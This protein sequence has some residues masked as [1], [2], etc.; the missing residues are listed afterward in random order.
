MSNKPG[1]KKSA[2]T[3]EGTNKKDLD[4]KKKVN[5]LKQQST[6]HK[7]TAE[8]AA[9]EREW[10]KKRKDVK[11]QPVEKVDKWEEQRKQHGLAL[12]FMD[13]NDVSNVKTYKKIRDILAMGA[14]QDSWSEEKK[15]AQ[16]ARL[17]SMSE[18]EMDALVAAI[19]DEDMDENVNG[20]YKKR[21][22]SKR[23]SK[24]KENLKEKEKLKEKGKLVE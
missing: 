2:V 5:F 17:D 11:Q 14:K 9:E 6:K 24:K 1:L 8:R 3:A 7:T 21:R 4:N 12:A 23:K 22:K 18:E 19:L 13:D 16:R 10:A 20:G 15:K